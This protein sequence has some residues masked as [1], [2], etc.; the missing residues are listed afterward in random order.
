VYLALFLQHGLLFAG[1]A[2]SFFYLLYFMLLFYLFFKLALFPFLGLYAGILSQVPREILIYYTAVPKI[3]LFF[4]AKKI[5]VLFL[6]VH[7][8]SSLAVGAAV[9]LGV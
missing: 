9:A 1:A 4:L 8:V 6:G 5:F 2:Q 3:A 7:Q